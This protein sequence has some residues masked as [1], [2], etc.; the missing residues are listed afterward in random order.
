[1][2]ILRKIS[3]NGVEINISL[4]ESYNLINKENHPE[5]FD[6]AVE[7]G[8]VIS[9]SIIYGYIATNNG[10]IYPLSSK[11]Q[12]YIMTESGKTFDN[13]TLR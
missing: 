6:R 7:E 13:L 9:D 1:M 5:E 8:L 3:G 11:Q 4:G 2:F 12:A 10:G